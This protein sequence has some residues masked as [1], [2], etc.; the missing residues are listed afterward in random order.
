MNSGDSEVETLMNPIILDIIK[1][2]HRDTRT[3]AP[4]GSTFGSSMTNFKDGLISRSTSRQEISRVL[5]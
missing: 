4:K 2:L 1:S 5:L 3:L